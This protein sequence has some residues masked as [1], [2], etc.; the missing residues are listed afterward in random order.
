[1]RGG[2]QADGV[3]LVQHAFGDF[4]FAKRGVFAQREGHVL[5]YVQVGEKRA[6]LEQHAHALAQGLKLGAGDAR[7]VLA[8]SQHAA[9][10]CGELAGGRPQQRGLAGA[11]AAHDGDHLARPHVHGNVAQDGEITV[12]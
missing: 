5:E 6:L 9:M 8:E 3:K 10:L 11:G 1:M 7:H 2:A 12:A 4:R